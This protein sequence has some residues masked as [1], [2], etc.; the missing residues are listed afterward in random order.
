MTTPKW[1]MLH[2][3]T[4]KWDPPIASHMLESVG[5][6]VPPV[7]GLVT[8]R[9]TRSDGRLMNRAWVQA[10]VE[11][12]IPLRYYTGHPASDTAAKRDDGIRFYILVTVLSENDTHYGDRLIPE[13]VDDGS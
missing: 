9:K 13:M 12:V 6:V 8:F 2:F 11:E 10:R 1:T 4:A 5:G 7:G 3:I